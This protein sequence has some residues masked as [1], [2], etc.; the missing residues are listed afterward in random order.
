MNWQRCGHE[1]GALMISLSLLMNLLMKPSL[2]ILCSC[3]RLFTD[4]S[5][6]HSGALDQC[7]DVDNYV[8]I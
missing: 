5:E 4:S 6:E 3:G 1:V 7:V 8:I 2:K